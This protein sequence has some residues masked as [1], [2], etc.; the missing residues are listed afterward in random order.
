MKLFKDIP[1]KLLCMLVLPDV[2]D[3]QAGGLVLE[4]HSV[5]GY[6]HRSDAR[7]RGDIGEKLGASAWLQEFQIVKSPVPTRTM[8]GV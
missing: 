3:A 5:E 1:L 2:P 7:A 8:G 4:V 6:A